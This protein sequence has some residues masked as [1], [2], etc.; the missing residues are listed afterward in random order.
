MDVASCEQILTPMTQEEAD[1]ICFS[2]QDP[3]SIKIEF[4]TVSF[5]DALVRDMRNTGIRV[6]SLNG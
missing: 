2:T 6:N 5:K 3:K 4:H 1:I